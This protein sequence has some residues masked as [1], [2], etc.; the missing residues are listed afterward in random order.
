[1]A[2]LFRTG[3]F[4]SAVC[5][6]SLSSGTT[7][8]ARNYKFRRGHGVL[9]GQEEEEDSL[10]FYLQSGESDERRMPIPSRVIGSQGG[11]QIIQSEP[12][13][14]TPQSGS[15]GK[16]SSTTSVVTVKGEGLSGGADQVSLISPDKK[17][18]LDSLL[19][20]LKVS[21]SPVSGVMELRSLLM[22]QKEEKILLRSV[23]EQMRVELKGIK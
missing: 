1:M 17:D 20:F 2:M 9:T 15:Q 19:S 18:T 13:I 5:L 11:P 3:I 4:I 16:T 7:H 22:S 12:Q 6:S 14:P 10:P 8:H 21:G 23:V